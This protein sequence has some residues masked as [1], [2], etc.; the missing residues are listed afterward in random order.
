MNTLEILSDPVIEFDEK[1]FD[2]IIR[3]FSGGDH[4]LDH[5][6]N[7]PVEEKLKIMIEHQRSKEVGVT[8]LGSGSR[9][10]SISR[11]VIKIIDKKQMTIQEKKFFEVAVCG[12]VEDEKKREEMLGFSDTKKLTLISA[13]RVLKK[14]REDHVHE[15]QT[16]KSEPH[17][18]KIRD[19]IKVEKIVEAFKKSVGSRRTKSDIDFDKLNVKSILATS[20]LSPVL[21]SSFLGRIVET[22]TEKLTDQDPSSPVQDFGSPEPSP[23]KES[24]TPRK[25]HVSGPLV[26]LQSH[27]TFAKTLSYREDC[28][29]KMIADDFADGNH[30]VYIMYQ[31]LSVKAKLALLRTFEQNQASIK[32]PTE[33]LPL[34]QDGTNYIVNFGA[35]LTNITF[36]LGFW[37]HLVLEHNSDPLDFLLEVGRLEDCISENTIILF[38][39]VMKKYILDKSSHELNFSGSNKRL[40][41]EIIG[42]RAEGT[43]ELDDTPRLLL[44]TLRSSI[45]GDLKNDPFERFIGT[46]A[47]MNCIALL[48]NDPN[49]IS[50]DPKFFVKC[51]LEQTLVFPTSETNAELDKLAGN[52]SNAVSICSHYLTNDW[53]SPMVLQKDLLNMFKSLDQST[54]MYSA[55]EHKPVSLTTISIRLAWIPI[56]KSRLTGISVLLSPFLDLMTTKQD[57]YQIALIF[58]SWILYFDETEVCIPKR[59]GTLKDIYSIELDEIDC[60]KGGMRV[61]LKKAAQIIAKWNTTR[62]YVT[63]EKNPEV[64]SDSLDFIEDFLKEIGSKQHLSSG[65]IP[66]L[67]QALSHHANSKG[68][69]KPFKLVLN[70]DFAFDFNLKKEFI[71]FSDHTSL[72]EF[73]EWLMTVKT[74]F[75]C[76]YRSEYEI[77]K[78]FDQAWWR[79]FNYYKLEIEAIHG[80]IY[81]NEQGLKGISKKNEPDLY[82]IMMNQKHKLQKEL[83]KN[84]AQVLICGSKSCQ[85][86]GHTHFY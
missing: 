75:A 34:L 8:R 33:I 41:L 30:S 21:S 46:E 24:L 59:F 32:I 12:L 70:S 38:D 5:Y 52:L 78:A 66:N 65:C 1:L 64:H 44:E 83:K 68:I 54:I 40:L 79:K 36:K 50:K 45:V 3:S 76:E 49:V 2:S 7:L 42:D 71:E 26:S 85:F 16:S 14:K 74:D 47:G 61:H 4:E 39:H 37:N 60:E 13:Y 11:P 9:S 10:N 28:I 15:L 51:K 29:F 53:R 84:T 17:V 63:R 57:E 82:T 62:I 23:R 67:I 22:F 43:W 35:V 18:E 20:P 19:T 73:V 72:D 31:N 80:K 58:G 56:D 69:T 86:T 55:I 77:L 6:G 25:V 81:L 48:W 27:H